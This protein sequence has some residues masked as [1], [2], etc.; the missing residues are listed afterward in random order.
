MTRNPHPP[1]A[2]DVLI[3]RPFLP[4]AT[5]SLKSVPILGDAMDLVIRFFL[6]KYVGFPNSIPIV[7]DPAELAGASHIHSTMRHIFFSSCTLQA[8]DVVSPISP[9]DVQFLHIQGSPTHSHPISQLLL[10]EPLPHAPPLFVLCPQSP[11]GWSRSKT[12]ASAASAR[13]PWRAS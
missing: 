13:S 5:R 7:L 3:S 10:T 9:P 2:L 4:S 1:R 12:S 11:R 6:M 8:S